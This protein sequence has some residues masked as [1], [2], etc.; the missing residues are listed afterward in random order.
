MA[1]HP[2]GIECTAV[3]DG[4]VTIDGAPHLR[5]SIVMQPVAAAAG[6]ELID[7]PELVAAATVDVTIELKDGSARVNKSVRLSE[8]GTLR[9]PAGFSPLRL[10]QEIWADSAVRARY[11]EQIGGAPA[12]SRGTGADNIEKYGLAALG[13]LSEHRV[14]AYVALDMLAEGK[15]RGIRAREDDGEDGGYLARRLQ[16]PDDPTFKI[17]D[18][19]EHHRKDAYSGILIGDALDMLRASENRPGARPK[20]TDIV[21]AGFGASISRVAR[22][23]LDMKFDQARAAI[24]R[25][26]GLTSSTGIAALSAQDLQGWNPIPRIGAPLPR[27]RAGDRLARPMTHVIYDQLPGNMSAAAVGAGA[28][29]LEKAVAAD[30][31]IAQIAQESFSSAFADDNENPD[32]PPDDVLAAARRAAGLQAHPTLRKLLNLIIDVT[33]PWT[34][35]RTAGFPGAG[36]ALGIVE[37]R[38]GAPARVT[39]STFALKS[40]EDG[41]GTRPTFFAPCSRW[42]YEAKAKLAALTLDPAFLPA[43]RS[44][45]RSAS[46]ALPITGGVVDLRIDGVDGKPRFSL[47]SFDPLAATLAERQAL[48]ATLSANRNAA[49]PDKTPVDE[50]GRQTRG[51]YL[52]DVEAHVTA[53]VA[54]DRAAE[55]AAVTS[56]SRLL[57]AEDLVD[58]YRLDVVSPSNKVYPAGPRSLG[59]APLGSTSPVPS[60]QTDVER[61]K[62]SESEPSQHPYPEFSTRDEGFFTIGTRLVKRTE[63]DKTVIRQYAS[64]VL[65]CWTGALVGMPA[66]ASI[67][68]ENEFPEGEAEGG[69]PELP[70]HITYAFKPGVQAPILRDNGGYRLLLRPRWINGGSLI[71]DEA[72]TPPLSQAL[73]DGDEPFVFAP[74]ERTPGPDILIPEHEAVANKWPLPNESERELIL[75]TD[76][77]RTEQRIVRRV[78]VSPRLTRDAAERAGLFDEPSGRFEDRAGLDMLN[79]GH[80][81]RIDLQADGSYHPTPAKPPVTP[82][83]NDRQAVTPP[84]ANRSV[85][86][87][88]RAQ[89]FVPHK[90]RHPFWC[91]PSIRFV[92]ARLKATGATG[93]DDVGDPPPGWVGPSLWRES[94]DPRRQAQ[95]V[96]LEVVELAQGKS[97]IVQMEDVKVDGVNMSTLRVVV[98]PAH[99]LELGLWLARDHAHSFPENSATLRGAQRATGLMPELRRLAPARPG[100]AG[101]QDRA[102]A[103]AEWHKTAS[104]TRFA[105]LHSLTRL[106]IEH[107][108]PRPL[109]IP[110]FGSGFRVSRARDR[111]DWELQTAGNA[112]A[113]TRGAQRCFVSGRIRFDRRSTGQL[114]CRCAWLDDDPKV[115]RLP[116]NAT[117][118]THALDQPGLYKWQP[119]LCHQDLFDLEQVMPLADPDSGARAT[120]N[121]QAE[122]D[123]IRDEAG[124][125]RLLRGPFEDTRARRVAVR[126][127]ARTRFDSSYP[128]AHP[129]ELIEQSAEHE[130]LERAL[131]TGREIAGVKTFWIP[132]TLPPPTVEVS[133][134]KASIYDRHYV[135]L[136][137]LGANVNGMQLRHTRR[138]WLGERWHVS[139]PEKLAI[140]CVRREGIP[141]PHGIGKDVAPWLSRWGTDM[142]MRAASRLDSP[143]LSSSAIAGATLMNDVIFPHPH[144]NPGAGGDRTVD[145]AILEPEF[146]SGTGE[147]FCKL[148]IAVPGVFRPWVKLGVMRYQEHAIEGCEF[149]E[150][151]VIEPFLLPQPWELKVERRAQHAIV[152]ATGPAYRERAPSVEQL[153]DSAE[154]QRSV[155]GLSENPIVQ[156]ELE[157]TGAE[158]GPAVI[159]DDDQLV[160]LSSAGTELS[161]TTPGLYSWTARVPLP[162]PGRAY[163]VRAGIATVQANAAAQLEVSDEGALLELPDPYSWVIPVP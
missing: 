3:P 88:Y 153:Q 62:I 34:D 157:D 46:S 72:N 58:G 119:P 127:V 162:Q 56:G 32:R 111:E 129:E 17:T 26:S 52:L 15:R 87:I 147:W 59:Y 27:T 86:S 73:G 43:A 105:S 36:E 98:A 152:T 71:F 132:S 25:V 106:R 53:Q 92:G 66:H 100:A 82:P 35:L 118:D 142:T 158:A 5:V 137:G 63:D 69:Y 18:A 1:E 110:A 138:L 93:A 28:S 130:A 96:M 57:Y 145:L 70:V 42:E 12:Q 112:I 2:V 160:R 95:P 30:R 6:G 99:T 136:P 109:A 149:S 114:W 39:Q 133:R 91:D 90:R 14:A 64:E 117:R 33:I 97:R 31:T 146:D 81:Q 20:P 107:H 77:L 122:L 115:A 150:P 44:A 54:A 50:P 134:P 155:F 51:I 94:P 120:G 38:A 74:V 11:Y 21:S 47:S 40:I 144:P 75:R 156:L 7:F 143:F 37:A 61:C 19:Q 85:G 16:R 101:A 116:T 79:Y 45:V 139:G 80:H 102:R 89:D 9:H 49:P 78:L 76:A 55:L 23:H 140:I 104:H 60:P 125:L 123:L 128:D 103:E 10:W 148:D 131:R 121:T 22:A 68:N 159:G 13:E 141:D 135:P 41:A 65:L 163:A 154:A 113:D 67:E 161:P 24:R 151:A 124:A 48:A 4:V 84:Q 126:L 108:V 29:D 83:P 8:P